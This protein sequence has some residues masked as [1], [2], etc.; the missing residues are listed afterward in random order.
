MGSIGAHRVLFASDAPMTY[1]NL[2]LE[3]LDLLTLGPRERSDIL[4]GNLSRLLRLP[5]VE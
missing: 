2:E 4:G 5:A 1:L 3:K